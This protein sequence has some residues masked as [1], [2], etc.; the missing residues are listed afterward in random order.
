MC[1]CWCSL[2]SIFQLK[3]GI[4]HRFQVQEI[5]KILQFITKLQIMKSILKIIFLIPIVICSCTTKYIKPL[6]R[7]I[8][9][10]ENVYKTQDSLDLLKVYNKT[11]NYP[12]YDTT[13]YRIKVNK[14]RT[15][16]NVA[17]IRYSILNDT[18]SF[19]RILPRM[20][21]DTASIKSKLE[22]K[23]DSVFYLSMNKV[24]SSADSFY[25]QF[26]QSG[27]TPPQ[28]YLATQHITG[29]PLTIPV[30]Y[31]YQ[32]GSNASVSAFSLSI[33][34]NYAFGYKI[35]A[36]DNPYVPNFWRFLVFT[37]FASENYIP[38]DSITS[39]TYKPIT[40]V[41]WSYGGGVTFEVGNRFNLGIMYGADRMFGNKKDWY[42][43]NKAWLGFGIGF[44]F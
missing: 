7:S 17:F 24:G 4:F 12:I 20:Y 33:G 11:L 37:G 32:T 18:G 36:N 41:I 23:K 31:R 3:N 35:R 14:N 13:T 19:V 30:K 9:Y 39:T 8:F 2:I 26:K 29:L 34:I 21:I 15:N 27:Q 1:N 43:E 25:F 22:P 5:I 6:T 42:Y 10:N 28:K 16:P 44:K 38:K 40:N